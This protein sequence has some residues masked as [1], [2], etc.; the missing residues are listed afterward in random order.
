[1][2][3]IDNKIF[4]KIKKARR[5]TLFYTEDFLSFGTHK[6]ISKALERL[7]NEGE[8]SRVARGIFSILERDPILGEIQPTA[9]KIAE[10]IRKR[11]K[12]RIVPSG[13]LAL[14]ALGLSTQVPLN[15]VYYTD[16][17]ARTINLGNRKVVFK[18]AS[19]KNL[20]AI[21]KISGLVIQA[22]KELGKENVRDEE[23]EI[24]LKHLKN[25]DPYRLEHDIKL[26]PEWIR[27]IMRKA[28]PKDEK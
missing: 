23:I 22:L 13:V 1:M 5:G 27:I 11:D 20:S 12:A 25:E 6:A 7:V 18:K 16:G 8:I 28:L 17:S 15:L 19:P 4:D 3:S 24:I 14:N 10:S 9:E 26:A 2:K 21:G